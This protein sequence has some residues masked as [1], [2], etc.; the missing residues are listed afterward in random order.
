M[1]I[2]LDFNGSVTKKNS[3]KLGGIESLNVEL[4]NNLKKTFQELSLKNQ[5]KRK[6]LTEKWD[7]I[8]SSNNARIFNKDKNNKSILW[9]H[10]KIQIEKSIRK[11]QLLSI[12]K[13]DIHA[14]FVSKYL[15]NVTSKIYNFKTRNVIPNFLDKKFEKIKINFNRKP[16]F[17]WSVQRDRGLDETINVW[18]NDIYTT[19]PDAEFHIFGIKKNKKFNKYKKYNIFLHGRVDKKILIRFYKKSFAMICLGFD[20][21]FCLNAIESMSCG[22]PVISFNKTALISLIKNDINGYKVKN[23]NDLSKKIQDMI[24]LNKNKR[25]KL[26]RSTFNY[27]KKFHFKNIKKKWIDLISK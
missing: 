21:T 22:L 11:K 8:I 12:L 2:L 6:Y 1:K 27:S 26:T 3:K 4:F 10:N 16:L 7:V 13:N 18:V 9:I 14:V 24:D 23:F 15:E 17:I 25:H 5:N 20:E 19:N